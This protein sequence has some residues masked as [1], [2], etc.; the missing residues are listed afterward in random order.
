[1]KFELFIFF[2]SSLSKCSHVLLMHFSSQTFQLNP[3]AFPPKKKNE[4]AGHAPQ[5]S[6]LQINP[7][8]ALTNIDLV[9]FEEGTAPRQWAGR[10]GKCGYFPG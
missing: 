8:A 6:D 2:V 7:R 1:M 5:W 4:F 10:N 3:F 9:H